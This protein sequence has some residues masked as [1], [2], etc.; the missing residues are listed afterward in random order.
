MV[1]LLSSA[2]DSLLPVTSGRATLHHALSFPFFLLP[3]AAHQQRARKSRLQIWKR[4][5]LNARGWHQARSSRAW[6]PGSTGNV[7]FIIV[8]CVTRDGNRNG[9]CQGHKMLFIAALKEAT[10]AKSA[11]SVSKDASGLI[12]M[13]RRDL[14]ASFFFFNLFI[15]LFLGTLM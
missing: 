15:Y 11:R 13:E 4:K 7:F 9:T 5:K 8:T 2:R 6:A 10:A 14:K 1:Y 3:P 12:I